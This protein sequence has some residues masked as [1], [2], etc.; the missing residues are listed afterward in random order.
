MRVCCV[1]QVRN[2]DQLDPGSLSPLSIPNGVQVCC[3][4]LW[5]GVFGGLQ[6][7]F[8]PGLREDVQGLVVV[9]VLWLSSW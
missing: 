7:K 3:R 2:L 5:V 4:R 9:V 1:G 6:E 8:L